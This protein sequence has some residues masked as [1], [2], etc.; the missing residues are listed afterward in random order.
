MVTD[1]GT[2][3]MLV[4]SACYDKQHCLCISATVFILDEPIAVNNHFLGGRSILL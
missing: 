3:K 4:T 1:V 2:F